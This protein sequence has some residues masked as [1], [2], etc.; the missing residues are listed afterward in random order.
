MPH[1]P[2]TSLLAAG[3]TLAGLAGDSNDPGCREARREWIDAMRHLK[4]S[5]PFEV[6]EVWGVKKHQNAHE[7]LA[8]LLTKEEALSFANRGPQVAVVGERL[9]QYAWHHPIKALRVMDTNGDYA[10]YPLLP[11]TQ[12]PHFFRVCTTVDEAEKAV[13]LAKLTERERQLLGVG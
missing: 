13:A 8:Y 2:F 10:Y 6:V 1:S 3:N 4:T 12:E 7:F 11:G 9:P 5:T